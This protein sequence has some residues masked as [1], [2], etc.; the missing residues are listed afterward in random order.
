VRYRDSLCDTRGA[1]IVLELV[2]RRRDLM[3]GNQVSL[4]TQSS[5]SILLPSGQSLLGREE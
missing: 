5:T 2:K 4:G 3:I 1:M